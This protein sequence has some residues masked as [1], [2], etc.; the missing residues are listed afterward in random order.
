MTER[1]LSA[2]LGSELS[3]VLGEAAFMLVEQVGAPLPEPGPAVEASVAFAGR[4][5]GRCW[6]SMS[7][8]AASHLAREMLGEDLAALPAQREQA[9]AELVNMLA[10]WL[11]DAWWGEQVEHSLGVPSTRCGPFELTV[12][13]SLPEERR[14]VIA[15]DAG[16]TFIGGVTLD[17]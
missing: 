13:W 11:L 1:S 10:A 14:S 12:T 17:D 3:R 15:T 8:Q 7:E 4:A 9:A 5:P 6:L 2:A 16:H